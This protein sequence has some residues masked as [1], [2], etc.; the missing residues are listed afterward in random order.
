MC[1]LVSFAG[2]KQNSEMPSVVRP[3]SYTG[4]HDVHALAGLLAYEWVEAVG[5]QDVGPRD[6][7]SRPQGHCCP[8]A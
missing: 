4:L 5:V 3:A 8:D 2:T 6:Q 7:A 1:R